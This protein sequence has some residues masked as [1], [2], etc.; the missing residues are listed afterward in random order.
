MRGVVRGSSKDERVLVIK[1]RIFGS[2][3]WACS[4]E[5]E[6]QAEYICVAGRKEKTFCWLNEDFWHIGREQEVQ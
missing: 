6:L 2:G 3:V 1:K 5:D 4:R